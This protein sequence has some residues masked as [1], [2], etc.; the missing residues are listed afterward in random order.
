MAIGSYHA[1][2]S[3][4]LQAPPQ[5]LSGALLGRS[6][7]PTASR[8]QGGASFNNGTSAGPTALGTAWELWVQGCTGLSVMTAVNGH[9]GTPKPGPAGVEAT[10]EH[11]LLPGAENLNVHVYLLLSR[12]CHVVHGSFP[13]HKVHLFFCF[14]GK[15]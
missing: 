4:Y 10:P 2:A 7:S 14:S 5:P 11:R 13:T 15:K 8:V 12:V 3:A 9:G 1:Q 6:L